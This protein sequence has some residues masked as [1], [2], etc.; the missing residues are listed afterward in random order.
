[1]ISNVKVL[2]GK[3]KVTGVYKGKPY[4]FGMETL[5]LHD[6]TLHNGRLHN[7]TLHNDTVQNGTLQ[8]G[9]AFLNG[10]WFKAVCC[11]TTLPNPCYGHSNTTEFHQ[12]YQGLVTYG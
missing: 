11:R 6:G 1:M 5:G 10:T 8:N 4:K 3:K 12:P 2:D 7:G 9:T